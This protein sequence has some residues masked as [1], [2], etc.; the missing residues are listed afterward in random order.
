LQFTE[1]KIAEIRQASDILGLVRQYVDLKRVGNAYKGLCPFH[2]EKTP[3]FTVNPEKGFFHCFGCGQGGDV[4][5]FMMLVTQMSFP[6][7]LEELARRSGISLPKPDY[8]REDD[9]AQSKASKAA[10]VHLM[11]IASEF[12][13][14]CLWQ[15]QAGQAARAYLAKRG[16]SDKVSRAFGLGLN[17]GS[18]DG[19]YKYLLSKGFGDEIMEECGLIKYRYKDERRVG[20]YDVFRGRLIVPVHDAQGRVVAFAG[21]LLESSQEAPK[22]INSKETP[23]YKKGNIL[24]GFHLSRAHLRASGMAFVVEGYFDLIALYAAGIRPVVA[25]MG[26]ALSQAQINLLGRQTKQIYLV[27][28]S[29]QAGLKAAERALPRLLNADLEGRVIRLPD[30][31]DPDSFV[32]QKGSQAFFELVEESQELLDFY[33]ARLTEDT[34]EGL[35]DQ[36]RAINRAKD[37]LSEVKDGAKGQLLKNR[38][39][40]KLGLDRDFLP[41]RQEKAEPGRELSALDRPERDYSPLAGELL[42]HI[43]IHRECAVLLPGLLEFWPADGSLSVARHLAQQHEATGR[44]E[45]EALSFQG[46]SGLESLLS[47]ALLTPRLLHPQAAAAQ[48]KDMGNRLRIQEA[49]KTQRFLTQALKKAEDDGDEELVSKL[50]AQINELA[51]LGR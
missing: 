13:S 16:I 31:H 38:L 17:P 9:E 51:K 11:E 39:A 2:T 35:F 3:S 12:F 24:F 4:I 25:A 43:V 50:L 10:L 5:K 6:E 28:D 15:G 40:D 34:G 48:A 23:L 30:G 8:S 46:M 1:D 29:D 36:A 33:L 26:T 27:F 37:M 20:C 42:K 41:L 7:A 47:E 49:K 22:Y 21:R 44:I 45:P 14:D 32:R 19:L 18:W